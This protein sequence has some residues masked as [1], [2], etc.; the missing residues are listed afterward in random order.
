MISWLN[1]K[2]IVSIR[3]T[4]NDF[5]F[6]AHK[7]FDS[8][9]E[10]RSS[11]FESFKIKIPCNIAPGV[12][13]KILHFAQSD[14]NID[15]LGEKMVVLSTRDSNF[16]YHEMQPQQNLFNRTITIKNYTSKAAM[17]PYVAIAD[18]YN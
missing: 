1:K 6:L 3:S 11:K 2:A 12:N 9:Y 15:G 13:Q 5:V 17:W 7:D 8:S 10:L 16:F 18:S 4:G 14:I